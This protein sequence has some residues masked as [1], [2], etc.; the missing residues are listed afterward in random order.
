MRIPAP[1]IP[2][3]RR[4]PAA[5]QS[6]SPW[7]F[8]G[9][10]A[11]TF[12]M[13]VAVA[14]AVSGSDRRTPIVKAIASVKDSVVNIH[15]QK[16][17]GPTDEPVARGEIPRK[18]N[19]M[20]TG[21]I[22]DERGYIITNFHV[23]DGVQ[24][25]EVT[26][27]DGTDYVAQPVAS[28]PLAD[29]AVIKIS[30]PGKLPVIP[31]GTSNDMLIG[32]TVIAVGNAYG[33]HDTVTEGIV[34]A[35]HRSVQVSD[36]QGYEDLI[37]TSAQINPGNSGGPL[38]N[39]DGEM[40]GINVAVRAGAQGIGFAI[41]VDKAMAVAARLISVERLEKH[42]HG[43]TVQDGAGSEG[44][45]TVSA[46]EKDSPAAQA[47]LKPGDVIS[48][49]DKLQIARAL[50]LERGLLGRKRGEEVPL[51]VRRNNQSVKLNLA[52]AD[53]PTRSTEADLA[54]DVLGLR[55]TP[56]P[57]GQFKQMQAQSP[58]LAA[59][60]GGLTVTEIRP[61]SPAARRYLRVG[62]VLVGMHIW[63]TV[64]VENVNYILTRS[65][66]PDIEPMKFY[67]VRGKDTFYGHFDVAMKKASHD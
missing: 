42:W 62:D 15:G 21:V 5:A 24:K 64:S 58:R 47:G 43:I 65:D 55:L 8:H 3:V 33:Y 29:L 66:L 35:L 17:L 10:A 45:L 4:L 63:E 9:M 28:D 67:I 22:F 59:Y 25:I 37:Q 52:L 61:D 56:I 48:A 20:G 50:D 32:E 12:C 39:V 49:V 14:A 46:V 1:C 34:S 26:L 27:A 19:G 36:S 54:W 13:L 23:V 16:T 6:R 44:G 18:V 40:I 51:T 57:A 31:T 30:A 7:R 53:L 2:P 11:A 60:K 38:V 41:P